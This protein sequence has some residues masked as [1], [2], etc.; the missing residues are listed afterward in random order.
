MEINLEN[1]EKKSARHYFSKQAC[2]VELLDAVN[3]TEKV[4]NSLSDNL[5]R[6][7]QVNFDTTYWIAFHNLYDSCNHTLWSLEECIKLGNF[8][9]AIMLVRKY[10]DDLIFYFYGANN[11]KEYSY[12]TLSD[13]PDEAKRKEI[14]KWMQNRRRDFKI[15]DAVIQFS[16]NEQY[17]ELFSKFHIIGQYNEFN[18]QLNS[19]AHTNGLVYINF[20]ST[21]YHYH[22]NILSRTCTVLKEN[23]I[24]FTLLFL[25]L[26]TI[27]NPGCISS[28]DHIFSLEMGLEPEAN[29]QFWVLPFIQEYFKENEKYLGIGLSKYLQDLTSM[30]LA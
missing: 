8:S 14:D 29:S 18:K 7:I 2:V 1:D 15:R 22:H 21:F 20:S 30:E 5:W 10:R 3:K 27:L 13:K 26:Q 4:I 16:E 17:E 28:L 12:S 19:F 11:Y 24:F 9:D 23:I 25:S 6:W